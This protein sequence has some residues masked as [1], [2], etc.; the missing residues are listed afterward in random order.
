MPHDMC[1]ASDMANEKHLHFQ[2]QRFLKSGKKEYRTDSVT[3]KKGTVILE[4]SQQLMFAIKLAESG[5]KVSIRESD[6]VQRQLKE[7]YGDLFIY[8]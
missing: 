5:I 8:E 6:E 3:Y 1:V 2:V 7:V 4:E